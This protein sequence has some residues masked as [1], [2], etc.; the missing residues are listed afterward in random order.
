MMMA[1]ATE[2]GHVNAIGPG[3][4]VDAPW[5]HA[6]A[7]KSDFQQVAGGLSLG[8]IRALAS[9][10]DLSTLYAGFQAY[11]DVGGQGGS[12]LFS[13]TLEGDV[14]VLVPA[15]ELN[16]AIASPASVMSIAPGTDGTLWVI[17]QVIGVPT[18]HLLRVDP[19]KPAGSRV[20]SVLDSEEL[21]KLLHV[22]VGTVALSIYEMGNNL[23][24]DD[25]GRVFFDGWVHIANEETSG[26]D[27]R[28]LLRRGA[29]GTIVELTKFEYSPINETN[30]WGF[31]AYP[32]HGI[33]NGL[34]WDPDTGMLV[35]AGNGLWLI[36]PDVPGSSYPILQ[37]ESI[38]GI[39]EQ[40]AG[41]DWIN[42]PHGA[43]GGATCLTRL[44]DGWFGTMMFA[45]WAFGYDLDYLDY[46]YDGLSGGEEA[47]R[48]TDPKLR[49]TDGGGIS[50][51]LEIA[52]FTDPL[53]KADDRWFA[54]PA[55][56]WTMS[57]LYWGSTF[58]ASPGGSV[59]MN[60]LAVPDGRLIV[61]GALSLDDY[62]LYVFE[63][64]DLPALPTGRKAFHSPM[65][66]DAKGNV[67]GLD[68]DLKPGKYPVVRMDKEG[69]RSEVFPETVVTSLVGPEPVP[70]SWMVDPLGRVW[71]GY[72]DGKILRS[73]PND[74][75][76]LVYDGLADLVSVQYMN[77]DGS[78]PWGNCSV[79][80]SI[81]AMLFEEVRGIVYFAFN[82]S[83]SCGDGSGTSPLV[84]AILPDGRIVRVADIVDFQK[85][86]ML[87]GG[88][89]IVDLAPDNSGGVYVLM[90]HLIDRSLHRI[91]ASWTVHAIETSQEP[92]RPDGD[93]MSWSLGH[94]TDI[95]VLPDG[96]IFT[97]GA[98][99]F[100]E[101]PT[102]YGLI[103]IKPVDR[104][105]RGGELLVVLPED[106]YLGK[107]LPD[108]G[109]AN[110]LWSE[111][112]K[113]PVGVAGTEDLVAVSD[114]D[115]KGVLLFTVGSDGKLQEPE[116]VGGIPAPAGLDIDAVGNV[117]VC[118]VAGNRVVRVAADGTLSD[119]ASGAPLSAPM[120]VVAT[121]TGGF[122]VANH[123]GNTLLHYD[124]DGVV[125]EV[126]SV[127]SPRSL[128]LLTGKGYAVSSS[129]PAMSPFWL[130]DG[131]S[132]S[133]LAPKWSADKELNNVPGGIAATADGTL[134]WFDSIG[135]PSYLPAPFKG[136]SYVYRI[137][138]GGSVGSLSRR[139]TTWSPT[140]GDVCRVR[141]RGEALPCEPG[142][143]PP[144]PSGD[145]LSSEDWG[146]SAGGGTSCSA[147]D[148]PNGRPALL[149]LGMLLA[150]LVLVRRCRRNWT[151]GVSTPVMV[152]LA[153]VGLGL[154]SSCSSGKGTPDQ[155]SHGDDVGQPGW[156]GWGSDFSVWVPEVVEEQCKGKALCPPGTDPECTADTKHR[157]CLQDES[158]CWV[159]SAQTSCLAGEKCQGGVCVGPCVPF[160]TQFQECG[161]DG[162]GGSCGACAEPGEV[163]CADFFCGACVSD[164]TGKQCGHDG[165]GG[166]CG[167]C[168]E[169]MVCAL[170]GCVKAGTGTCRQWYQC[171]ECELWDQDCW[172]DCGT[173]L[174]SWGKEAQ[175]KLS[176]CAAVHCTDCLQGDE[177]QACWDDCLFGHC[178]ME[179]AECFAQGGTKTCRQIYECTLGCQ[180][181]DQPCLDEC[182][183]SASPPYL[184]YA[185]QWEVCADPFCGDKAPGLEMDQCLKG[186]AF[187]QCKTEFEMCMPQCN[188]D[189]GDKECG[190]S[191]CLFSCGECEGGKQCVDGKCQ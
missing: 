38:Q 22:P 21:V 156:D 57:A 172:D 78:V 99:Y 47:E 117:L 84:A 73:G 157:R 112:L 108:G 122:V 155:V 148:R 1:V 46:D 42:S 29:D 129:K 138:E 59:D 51:G 72:R 176:G 104:I 74:T 70:T 65:A 94:A 113:R 184:F 152:L 191:D 121:A 142:I 189:C 179:F 93:G 9:S 39:G 41:K 114:A 52:D 56:E 61:S 2:G 68:Y 105:V 177:A 154:S 136:M 170:G 62:E 11:G 53:D 31:F 64:W 162:C 164:C 149:V 63:G 187:D 43:A 8:E 79:G 180:E 35:G 33:W 24:A 23:T 131:V 145:D 163:C 44:G 128:V 58:Q 30:S 139:N 159:W 106:P 60:T 14:Q 6:V 102:Y 16:E 10:R 175:A 5:T 15:E 88:G 82:R 110:L 20:E 119:V 140:G 54:Q 165:A 178:A 95:T 134:F 85:A 107:L 3:Y 111:P 103:E 19:S 13:L 109:G 123:G 67:Y 133:A 150:A 101:Y 92:S 81:N 182:Y 186:V 174:D 135:S 36:D 181:G 45:Y 77:Q 71:V 144:P 171:T 158:G 188:P 37:P 83:I 55:E 166:T 89:D 137:P 118:D 115:L 97:V 169:G 90:T 18:R 69:M 125:Q 48:G 86:S 173:W 32:A 141:K 146:P 183:F 167:P 25:S 12:P 100:N 76:E 34:Q 143:E 124:A 151:S 185:L 4:F 130:V 75:V 28:I 153:V 161:D 120:D 160:C 190:P 66:G 98:T 147:H 96:R 80:L 87:Y 40:I 27:S 49:D 116:L 132:V 127:D 26:V 50:D 126:A 91:D 17:V 168:P 7:S